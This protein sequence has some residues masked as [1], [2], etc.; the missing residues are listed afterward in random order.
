MNQPMSKFV[1]IKNKY[2]KIEDII[3]VYLE[4][5]T[6][7]KRVFSRMFDMN[8]DDIGLYNNYFYRNIETGMWS[9]NHVSYSKLLSDVKM[10]RRMIRGIIKDNNAFVKE[11][12]SWLGIRYKK[13]NYIK[14]VSDVEEVKNLEEYLDKLE[15]KKLFQEHQKELTKMIMSQLITVGNNVNYR[16][17]VL[18]HTTLERII[19]DELKLEY[20]VSKPKKERSK[21]S[22][23]FGKNYIIILKIEKN[24]KNRS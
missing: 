16:T 23:F 9:L 10:C 13:N 7:D 15:G 1:G 17:K 14:N 3:D 4:D 6:K 22:Y 2:M 8:L 19:R 5:K 18:R 21:K 12:L 11:Q 20:A 24:K